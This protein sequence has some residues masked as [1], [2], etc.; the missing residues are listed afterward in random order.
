[1]MNLFGKAKIEG[2]PVSINC[3]E[4]PAEFRMRRAKTRVEN[5][6]GKLARL[7]RR[8]SSQAVSQM[9]ADTKVAI[10]SWKNVLELAEFEL[11][12]QQ[13]GFKQ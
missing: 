13:R 4:K 1:M 9:I 12:Q 7:H 11:K 5:L 6:T 10:H 8:P 2:Q 3:S